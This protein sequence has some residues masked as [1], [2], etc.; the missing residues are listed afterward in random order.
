M[1]SWLR[2]KLFGRRVF[3][4]LTRHIRHTRHGQLPA[5]R[6]RTFCSVISFIHMLSVFRWL[7]L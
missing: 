4:M 2:V 1:C 6:E 3:P 7:L 5:L